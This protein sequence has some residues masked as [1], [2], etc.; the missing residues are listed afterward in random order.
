MS[1]CRHQAAEVFADL[2]DVPGDAAALFAGP[3]FDLFSSR[4]WYRVVLTH[5]L[6]AGAVARFL[7]CRVDGRPAALLP[8]QI[9]KRGEP[10]HSLT[11]PYS[12]TYRPLVAPGL[13]D[14]ACREAFE[15][16][17]CFCRC[18]ATTR[19]DALAADEPA[20]VTWMNAARAGG[21]TPCRFNHFGNWYER[22]DGR[23]WEEYLAARPSQLRETVR[24]KLRRTE[25]DPDCSFEVVTGGDRLEPAVEAFERVYRQSWKQAEPFPY[26]SAAL[27]RETA[28]CGLLR[29]GLLRI[30]ERTVA[31]QLWVVQ[32]ER[33]IVLKL[34]HDE[35]WKAASPGTV[36]TSLMVRRLIEEERVPEI[37]FGRGDDA[38]KRGWAQHRRQRV[39]VVLANPRHPR[40][41]TFLARHAIGR[42]KAALRR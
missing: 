36:L 35:A 22:V 32:T 18:Y 9:L 14:V 19:V 31:A 40:G 10:F 8:M 33:A 12:C 34:A 38:Y 13:D 25:S 15:A 39:G 28:A 2:Q 30:G 5:G 29:L 42:A 21:L 6:P 41:I 3:E 17:A 24:R 4:V 27:I 26:F 7:V 16:F 1:G 37:D 23:S 20:L 11:T